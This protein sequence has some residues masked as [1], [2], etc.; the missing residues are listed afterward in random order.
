LDRSAAKQL[1]ALIDPISK[2]HAEPR[3][4]T[5]AIDALVSLRGAGP[6]SAGS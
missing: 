2:N 3:I 6:N 4:R 5:D 1:V